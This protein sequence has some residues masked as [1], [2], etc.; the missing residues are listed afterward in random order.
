M[1]LFNQGSHLGKMIKKKSTTSG[2]KTAVQPSLGKAENKKF[3]DNP[4]AIQVDCYFPI[5]G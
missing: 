2:K 3:D 5:V 1:K 4:A